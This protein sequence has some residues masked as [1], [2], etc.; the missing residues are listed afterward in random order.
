MNFISNPIFSKLDNNTE[1]SGKKVTFSIGWHLHKQLMILYKPSQKV[2]YAT[3]VH[4]ANPILPNDKTELY[5]DTYLNSVTEK[6]YGFKSYEQRVFRSL[7][8][9]EAALSIRPVEYRTVK[10]ID[11]HGNPYFDFTYK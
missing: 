1:P 4:V 8:E 6:N 11:S 5:H 9:K 2:N 10:K 7:Q 3:P